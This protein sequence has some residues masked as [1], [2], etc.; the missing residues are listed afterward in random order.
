[1]IK[2]TIATVCYN[3][4]DT[5]R[6]TLQSVEEQQYPAVEHLIIDGASK[7]ETL[8]LLQHYRE[9][10]ALRPAAERHEVVFRSE[11][12]RGLYDAMNKALLLARGDYILFL[13][14]GDRLHTPTT[15]SDIAASLADG[16]PSAQLPAVLYG[17]TD[18]VDAEGQF[19][20]HRRLSPPERLDW[21]SFRDGMLVCHQA[22]FART[23]L[24][25]TL[26][27]DLHYRFSAD[28]DWCIRLLRHAEAE[29]IDP[30]A[31][32]THLIVADYLSEGM[33]TRHHRASLLERYHIMAH[34]YGALTALSRHLWFVVRS[35]VKR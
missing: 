16:L 21:R 13:N 11:P 15:L 32:H 24:A 7:D 10:N 19:V 31:H 27:Y 26:P 1:M 14:A 22:F 23:D 8:A 3:A 17:H 20:R 34:H 2:F 33:T 35:V 5:L 4:A 25:R 9:C 18:L 28:F 12:D 6:T 30:V 29:G